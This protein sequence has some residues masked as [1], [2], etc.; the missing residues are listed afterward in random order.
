MYWN[1]RIVPDSL[2][3]NAISTRDI[4]GSNSADTSESTALLCICNAAL[5][6]REIISIY[7]SIL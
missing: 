2:S 6:V 5:S 7:K 4:T 1:F 3:R